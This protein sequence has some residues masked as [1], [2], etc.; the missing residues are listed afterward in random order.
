MKQPNLI[1]VFIFAVVAF[2]G[3]KDDTKESISKPEE[4]ELA[5]N[6]LKLN[7]ESSELA[8]QVGWLGGRLEG[9]LSE[10]EKNTGLEP[11]PF[12]WAEARGI[13]K[14]KNDP[15]HPEWYVKKPQPLYVP[16]P[17]I[18]KIAKAETHVERFTDPEFLNVY[19]KKQLWVRKTYMRGMDKYIEHLEKRLKRLEEKIGDSNEKPNLDVNKVRDSN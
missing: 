4:E 16:Y 3:C 12:D 15:N 11:M 18:A 19:I 6:V 17:P 8:I 1:I 7:D 14:F 5:L 9:C 13:P 10:L 2:S